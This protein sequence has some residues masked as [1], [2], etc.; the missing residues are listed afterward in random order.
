MEDTKPYPLTLAEWQEIMAIPAIRESWGIEDRT[1]PADFAAEVYA[2]MPP[3]SIS[4][5]EVPATLETFLSYRE[6]I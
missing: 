2:S 6:V 4:F 5:Q 3:N 1:T